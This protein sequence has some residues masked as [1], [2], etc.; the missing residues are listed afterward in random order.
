MWV[1]NHAA[2]NV[3]IST[4]DQICVFFSCCHFWSLAFLPIQTVGIFWKYF[5]ESDSDKL[6]LIESVLGNF[7]KT[8]AK[9]NLT[10]RNTEITFAEQRFQVRKVFV[11]STCTGVDRCCSQVNSEVHTLTTYWPCETATRTMCRWYISYKVISYCS[12]L[13]SHRAQKDAF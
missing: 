2:A 6:P 3:L 8:L 10:C 13:S 11:S 9:L 5:N 1:C 4:F 7:C 12:I